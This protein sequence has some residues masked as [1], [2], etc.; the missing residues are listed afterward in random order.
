MILNCIIIF[1][2]CLNKYILYILPLSFFIRSSEES[3]FDNLLYDSQSYSTI[4]SV[5]GRT[6]NANHGS[7]DADGKKTEYEMV[8]LPIQAARRSMV[9]SQYEFSDLPNVENKETHRLDERYEFCEVNTPDLGVN[10]SSSHPITENRGSNSKNTIDKNCCE[11]SGYETLKLITSENPVVKPPTSIKLLPRESNGEGN[12]SATHVSDKDYDRVY[13]H[14]TPRSTEEEDHSYS[15]VWVPQDGQPSPGYMRLDTTSPHL[16]SPSPQNSMPG[17]HKDSSV[18]TAKGYSYLNVSEIASQVVPDSTKHGA[19]T[20]GY[21][22]LDIH[23]MTSE[24]CIVVSSSPPEDGIAP[25]NSRKMTSSYSS[26]NIGEFNEGA[27]KLES[28]SSDS[29]YSHLNVYEEKTVAKY[30]SKRH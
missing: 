27:P 26:L 19:T 11:E 2:A 9:K 21:H 20:G 17:S 10:E 1:A 23:S 5:N 4:S 7:Q 6:D 30:L 15:H 22:S 13:S 3:H 29:G 28:G 8:D 14:T 24:P 25:T 16:L 18:V 12:Y